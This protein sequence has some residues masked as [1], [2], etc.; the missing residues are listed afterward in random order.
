[1][2]SAVLDEK[3]QDICIYIKQIHA[4]KLRTILNPNI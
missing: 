2:S 3:Y 1:M 4:E